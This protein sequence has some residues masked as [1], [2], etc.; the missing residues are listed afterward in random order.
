MNIL[1]IEVRDL[2][3]VDWI[4]FIEWSSRSDWYLWCL[5]LV[6]ERKTIRLCDRNQLWSRKP[7]NPSKCVYS[8]LPNKSEMQYLVWEVHKKHF[9]SF[10]LHVLLVSFRHTRNIFV[11]THSF[12][13]VM[14][15][16]LNDWFYCW[17]IKT[18]MLYIIRISWIKRLLKFLGNKNKYIEE[19]QGNSV[20]MK[21]FMVYSLYCSV[22]IK[23]GKLG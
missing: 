2:W 10:F 9:H 15:L 23:R 17:I 5:Q 19:F 11:T 14:S 8:I 21:P 1:R 16:S 22:D 12:R 20:W 3:S 6:I 18:H 4:S 7:I 13:Y